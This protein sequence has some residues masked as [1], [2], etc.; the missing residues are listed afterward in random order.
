MF[1][2]LPFADLIAGLPSLQFDLLALMAVA[3]FA[4][5]KPEHDTLWDLSNRIC[6]RYLPALKQ[7]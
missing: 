3:L 5:N 2:K 4:Q 6:D 7:A 1:S